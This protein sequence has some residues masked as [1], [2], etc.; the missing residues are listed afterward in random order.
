MT[1]SIWGSPPPQIKPYRHTDSAASKSD[2][3]HE[4]EILKYIGVLYL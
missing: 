3:E 4:I 2:L 1:S